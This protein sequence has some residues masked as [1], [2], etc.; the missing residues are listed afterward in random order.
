MRS[1]F[2]LLLLTGVAHGFSCLTRLPSFSP[3]L[4]ARRIPVMPAVLRAPPAVALAKKK[5]GG[6]KGGQ[7]QVVLFEPI[8][9]VGKKGEIVSVKSSYAENVILRGGKGE[10]ATDDKLAEI[11]ASE[12]AKVAEAKAA[13][14]LAIQK[15]EELTKAFGE[16][17]VQIKKNA[18]PDGA[19]FGSVTKT[20]ILAML[21]ETVPGLTIKIGDIKPPDL[22]AVGEGTAEITLH[23]EVVTKLKVVVSPTGSVF[24]Q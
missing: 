6:S 18:G 7:V 20:E 11:A 13:K 15:G 23:K 2:G 8:K 9:G 17:G 16:D 5:G 1:A 10:L 12:A 4:M 3:D 22:K 21:Q 14:D 19:L 24:D